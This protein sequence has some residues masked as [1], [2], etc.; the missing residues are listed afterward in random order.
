MTTRRE[1]EPVRQLL[2]ACAGLAARDLASR[3]RPDRAWRCGFCQPHNIVRTTGPRRLLLGAATIH[4]GTVAAEQ[5]LNDGQSPVPARP[6]RRFP[7]SVQSSASGGVVRIRPHAPLQ[8]F[9]APA[10][11]HEG[12]GGYVL[13]PYDVCSRPTV[14]MLVA[15]NTVALREGP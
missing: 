9:A 4:T 10:Q 12:A 5:T 8:A 11:G 3:R 2:Y 15:L 6:A 14:V 7:R 1:F 13:R